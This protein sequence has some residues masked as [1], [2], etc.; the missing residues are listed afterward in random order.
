MNILGATVLLT[1]GADKILLVTDGPCPFVPAYMPTQP[2][3]A[4]SFEA[5]QGTGVEYCRHVF[6]FEPTVIN[7]GTHCHFKG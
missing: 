7:V 6:G 1:N 2:K 5:S 4:L 3:L